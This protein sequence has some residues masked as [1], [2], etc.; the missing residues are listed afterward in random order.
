[1]RYSFHHLLVL[2]ALVFSTLPILGCGGDDNSKS[3]IPD[4][5]PQPQPTEDDSADDL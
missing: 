4:F 5:K 1:M 3:Y 2:T